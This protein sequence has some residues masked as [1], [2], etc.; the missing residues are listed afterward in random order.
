MT[1][2]IY[3]VSIPGE[4]S[5]LTFTAWIF[6]TTR[7]WH[8]AQDDEISPEPV[9]VSSDESKTILLAFD[10]ILRI[11]NAGALSSA[12]V[13]IYT[14]PDLMPVLHERD[15]LDCIFGFTNFG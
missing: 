10:G 11:D 6:A 1:G 5:S 8:R 7:P 14:D 12:V 9:L 15:D 2:D 13:A 4:T 3:T